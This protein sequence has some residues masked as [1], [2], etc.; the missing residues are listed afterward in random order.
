MHTDDCETHGTRA[1]TGN[2]PLSLDKYQKSL[3]E[4]SGPRPETTRT[5]GSLDRC[6]RPSPP[7]FRTNEIQAR[8][9]S[10]YIIRN[11][12]SNAPCSILTSTGSPL[13]VSLLTLFRHGCAVLFGCCLHLADRSVLSCS[14]GDISPELP[15]TSSILM[16]SRDSSIIKNGSAPPAR[17]QISL[18]RSIT[19]GFCLVTPLCLN[20]GRIRKTWIFRSHPGLAAA[21]ETQKEPSGVTETYAFATRH[22]RDPNVS[23]SLQAKTVVASMTKALSSV[24]AIVLGRRSGPSPPSRPRFALTI[25]MLSSHILA[26]TATNPKSTI[27]STFANAWLK[28]ACFLNSPIVMGPMI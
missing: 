6:L 3:I 4:P 21:N 10:I 17:S 14:K 18:R 1:G 2:Q 7:L 20:T 9:T 5:F 19:L 22:S 15:V 24:P 28:A 25:A 23:T 8:L 16:A 13:G 26:T 11:N 27:R 12:R